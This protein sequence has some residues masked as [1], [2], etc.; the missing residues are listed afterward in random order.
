[1]VIATIVKYS[2]ERML[3]KTVPVVDGE[4]I[5]ETM[6]QNPFLI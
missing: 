1:M 3:G 4:R 6:G 5:Y 2:V